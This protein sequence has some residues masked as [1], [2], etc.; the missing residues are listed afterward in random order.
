[1]ADLPAQTATAPAAIKTRTTASL[2][3]RLVMATLL[4]CLV[5]TVGTV[6][7]RTWF[8][9]DNNV[10]AM[11][12]ELHLIDQVFQGT[13][14]KAV[15]EMD[16]NALDEQLDSVAA[17]APVGRVSLRIL[18]PGRAADVMERQ[19]SD[20]P[21]ANSAPSLNRTLSIAPYPGATEEVG[22][23]TII[24]NP[25]V[26]WERLW[27]EVAV[28]VLTQVI[29]SLA[30]AGLIMALFNRTV[31]V[32]V[33]HV[34]RHLS[35]LTP[36]TLQRQ[37]QLRRSRRSGDELDLLEAGVNQVQAKLATYL[38]RQHEDEQALAASRDQ[39]AVL[40]EQRT[41]QL[42]AANVRLEAL[43]RF[44][45]LTGLAN[46]RHFDELK[47]LEF[48]RAV[49][50]QAPLAVLMCDIDHFKYYNDTHG[51][52]QGDECLS[53][54]AAIMRDAFTRSGEVVARLGGEEFAVLLPGA[55]LAQ[56]HEAAARLQTAMATA[57]VPHG[58]SPVSPYLTLS[59]GVAEMDALTMDRFD[60]L[61]QRADQALYRAKRQ[62]RAR[63]VS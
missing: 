22:E 48:T 14:A 59:I 60:Q 30:L 15:W 3:R 35:C 4:F 40:V 57:R 18:R 39:L 19:R 36:D 23:L 1:M 41:A 11:N 7:V 10:K 53:T 62:G 61:L 12:T 37:L 29:Q 55:A 49:R 46:R 2:G 28:I 34:A 9:W 32:H 8:A 33:R 43:T 45:P 6:A 38:Q 21:A 25:S 5:F 26:L 16:R 27:K 50:Q 44:D 13:L 63:S 54:V 20:L 56:A 52:A 47:H 24:G 17:A 31:T 51:H 58:A 42:R